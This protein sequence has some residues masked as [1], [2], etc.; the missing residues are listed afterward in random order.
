MIWILSGVGYVPTPNVHSD[1]WDRVESYTIYILLAYR[2]KITFTF[3]LKLIIS[4]LV[5]LQH[6]LLPSLI[7]TSSQ[8][9]AGTPL[10]LQLCCIS[11]LGPEGL[12]QREAM[13]Q[14]KEEVRRATRNARTRTAPATFKN[15]G[16]PDKFKMA[17]GE[18]WINTFANLPPTIDLRGV[19][20]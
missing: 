10:P 4:F 5:Q 6:L 1:V 12:L 3:S 17:E 20:K 9:R 19:R 15:H 7:V 14:R 16:Q 8:I 11:G 2:L 18:T 13:K